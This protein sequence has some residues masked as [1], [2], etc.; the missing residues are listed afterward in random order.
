MLVKRVFF[1]LK[2]A[3]A[4]AVLYFTSR[5]RLASFVYM[6]PKYFKYSTLFCCFYLP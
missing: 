3:F 2:A 6:L 1:L 4:M 5:V